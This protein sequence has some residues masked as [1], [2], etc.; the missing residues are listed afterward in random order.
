MTQGNHA[1][2]HQDGDFVS[3]CKNYCNDNGWWY[4]QPQASQE[5]PYIMNNFDLAVFP[6][7]MSRHHNIFLQQS[8]TNSKVQPLIPDMIPVRVPQKRYK[9]S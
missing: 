3:F 4:W 5:M 9:K 6:S 7:I 2:P 1:G 8:P